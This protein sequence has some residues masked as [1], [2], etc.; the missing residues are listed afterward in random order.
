[1]NRLNANVTKLLKLAL[2]ADNDLYCAGLSWYA[3]A[4]DYAVIL[5]NQHG[6]TIEQASAVIAALSPQTGWEPNKYCADRVMHLHSQ[7]LPVSQSDSGQTQANTSKALRIL[8]G[9]D[10]KTVLAANLPK[11]GHKVWSF[12]NNILNPVNDRG[13]TVDRHAIKAWMTDETWSCITPKRYAQIERDYQDVAT[14]LGILPHQAQ[15]II[16]CVVRGTAD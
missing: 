6:Y 4:H 5:A 11:S 14:S 9:E 13:V 7:G 12:F 8:D 10:V 1:V 2:D 16:W 3:S 15:A